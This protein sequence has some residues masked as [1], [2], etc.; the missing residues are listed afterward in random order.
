MHVVYYK[1]S[2]G[3]FS[4]GEPLVCNFPVKVTTENRSFKPDNIMWQFLSLGKRV[5]IMSLD[6]KQPFSIL[7]T[8]KE[9]ELMTP[10]H[11]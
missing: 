4:V 9:P 5:R 8:L 11:K 7:S 6:R 3:P 2:Q 10:A 1:N